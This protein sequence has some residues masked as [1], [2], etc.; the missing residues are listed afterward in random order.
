MQLRKI[1]LFDTLIM[2]DYYP[3]NQEAVNCIFLNVKAKKY[4]TFEIEHDLLI[5]CIDNDTKIYQRPD[6]SEVKCDLKSEN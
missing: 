3:N 2:E 5:V 6:Y 4:E 1:T